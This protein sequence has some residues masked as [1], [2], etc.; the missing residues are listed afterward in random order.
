[1]QREFQ[2]AV[3]AAPVRPLATIDLLADLDPDATIGWR[4]SLRGRIE[5]DDHSV[6]I[7][8]PH[9]TISL[10]AEA[11][12]AVHTLRESDQPAGALPGLDVGSSLVVSRRL[13]RE[14]VLV[15]R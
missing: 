5:D 4:D 3:R 2:Q 11:S 14:G 7:V 1:M 10:P 6:R 9:K 15:A 8:L 12:A 13:L